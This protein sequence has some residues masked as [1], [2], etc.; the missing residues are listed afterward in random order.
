[1]HIQMANPLG[2]L[3]FL[4]WLLTV[5]G[6]MLVTLARLMTRRA[7]RSS[8]A[9][10]LA[11]VL[12]YPLG[13]LISGLTSTERDLPMGSTQCFDDWCASVAGVQV[14]QGA[15]TRHVVLQLRVSNEA[16]RAEFAP[17]HPRL[18]LITSTNSEYAPVRAEGPALSLGLGSYPP[19]DQRLAAGES[20]ETRLLFEIPADE[21]PLKALVTE[22]T[23]P[24]IIGSGNSPWHARTY[25]LL[26]G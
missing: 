21:R 6:L 17:D 8:M 20:F 16:A 7:V 9:G 1:M 4:L 13:L 22:G 24:P 14:L 11:A 23:G 3:A 2:E 18:L 26:P 10:V 15:D 12:A 5:L 25:I 19:L